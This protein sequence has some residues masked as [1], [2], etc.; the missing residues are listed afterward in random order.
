MAHRVHPLFLDEL[1]QWGSDR[2]MSFSQGPE[3]NQPQCQPGI[4]L[5]ATRRR[6]PYPANPL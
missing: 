6:G 1:A 3:E 5:K 4:Q 2:A